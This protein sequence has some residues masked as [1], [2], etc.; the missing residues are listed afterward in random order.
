MEQSAF[1][2]QSW[3]RRCRQTHLQR[4][5]Y[6]SVRRSAVVIQSAFRGLIARRLAKRESAAQILQSY[7]RMTVYRKKFLQLRASAI[8]LQSYYRMRRATQMYKRQQTSA[9]IIQQWYISIVMMRRQRAAYL[10]TRRQITCVQAAVRR[11]IAQQ[12]FRKM[13]HAALEKKVGV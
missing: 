1:Q 8:I 2:I 3:F 6:L 12:E 11:F 5:Q 10:N 4:H 9:L 7:H 13:Q